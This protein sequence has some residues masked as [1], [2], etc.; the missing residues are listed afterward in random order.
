MNTIKCRVTNHDDADYRIS[1]KMPWYL[2][3]NNLSIS[4]R[5]DDTHY[6]TVAEL[7]QRILKNVPNGLED[8][9]VLG[10]S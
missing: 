7:I 9:G 5:Y 6:G 3:G 10:G 8:L 2:V 1:A 4:R